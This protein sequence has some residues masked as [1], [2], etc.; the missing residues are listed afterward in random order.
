MLN[1]SDVLKNHHSNQQWSFT[2][3]SIEKP[4]SQDKYMITFIKI[5]FPPLSWDKRQN[6]IVIGCPHKDRMSTWV[7]SILI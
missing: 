6:A 1:T 2:I 4:Q 3:N 5:Q 7:K